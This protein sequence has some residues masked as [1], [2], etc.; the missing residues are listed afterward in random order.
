MVKSHIKQI[1][2]DLKQTSNRQNA[3]PPFC[4]FFLSP[5][6][7]RFA[8]RAFLSCKAR[9]PETRV[10]LE[11]Q[12]ISVSFLS[13][14]CVMVMCVWGSNTGG[15]DTGGGRRGG[16]IRN[17]QKGGLRFG[18]AVRDFSFQM[19]NSGFVHIIGSDAHNTKKRSIKEEGNKK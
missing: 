10:T 14:M 3:K 2:T 4:F 16:L 8:R 13:V 6:G 1:E 19:L 18:D 12:H 15:S 9:V 7:A 17:L 5:R 11:R